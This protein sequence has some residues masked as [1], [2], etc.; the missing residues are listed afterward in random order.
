MSRSTWFIGPPDP[1]ELAREQREAI[2]ILVE[3]AAVSVT[4]LRYH[5]PT[6]QELRQAKKETRAFLALARHHYS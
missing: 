5:T 6:W 4:R 3:A 1:R 2:R